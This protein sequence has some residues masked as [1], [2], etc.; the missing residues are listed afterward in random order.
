M[1]LR[2]ARNNQSPLKE[3]LLWFKFSVCEFSKKLLTCNLTLYEIKGVFLIEP[4][5]KF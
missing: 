3:I 4:P 5:I 2:R 1:Y